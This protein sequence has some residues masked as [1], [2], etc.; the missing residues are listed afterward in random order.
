[1]DDSAILHPAFLFAGAHDQIK[2]SNT[3]FL[4]ARGPKTPN[5]VLS[6]LLRR[7]IADLNSQQERSL[8]G[9]GVG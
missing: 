6:M 9:L 3:L 7:S 4:V 8:D 5:C 1:M 2:H